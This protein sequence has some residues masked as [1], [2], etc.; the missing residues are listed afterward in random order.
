[1]NKVYTEIILF[2]EPNSNLLAEI[3]TRLVSEFGAT[4]IE[5]I[6]DLDSLYWDF[7]IDSEV[8]TLHQ[9]VF[10]GISIFPKDL[11]DATAKAN[12]IVERLGTF[13]NSSK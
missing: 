1:M 11:A 7:E 9:E 12:Q 2:D 4:S 8:V 13:L 6:Y 5:I 3:A 10:M